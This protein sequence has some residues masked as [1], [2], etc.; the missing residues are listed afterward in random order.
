MPIFKKWLTNFWSLFLALST[1]LYIAP[2]FSVYLHFLFK[3]HSLAIYDIYELLVA[4]LEWPHPV[5]TGVTIGHLLANYW[6][7]RHSTLATTCM[8]MH[9]DAIASCWIV[10]V[11]YIA[12]SFIDFWKNSR[13]KF[14]G[15][16]KKLKSLKI[17]PLKISNHIL[18]I[19][20]MYVAIH[21]N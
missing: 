2:A 14:Q 3:P 8:C 4:N 19:Y 17:W 21:T 6:L 13:M 9:W 15:W 7:Y 20:C 18:F 1:H 10:L 12:I 5:T 16:T 11:N